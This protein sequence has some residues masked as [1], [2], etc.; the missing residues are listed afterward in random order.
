MNN[1]ELL[2]SIMNYWE[3]AIN[4]D[5]NADFKV[6]ELIDKFALSCGIDERKLDADVFIT[7]SNMTATQKR[8]LW[9][10]LQESNII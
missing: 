7:V 3:R 4:K 10:M 8:K 9:N 5:G 2:T 6:N 1:N